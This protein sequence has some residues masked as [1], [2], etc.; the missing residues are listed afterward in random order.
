MWGV[1]PDW[2]R[3][4]SQLLVGSVGWQHDSVF[5]FPEYLLSREE[6]KAKGAGLFWSARMEVG[7]DFGGIPTCHA[8]GVGGE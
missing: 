1:F 6:Q 8:L 3:A 5:F 7:Q 2:R 4:V